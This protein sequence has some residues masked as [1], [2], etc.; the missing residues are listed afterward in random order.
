MSEPALKYKN[1]AIF[2][3]NYTKNCILLLKL[4]ILAVS[5]KGKSRFSRFLPKKFL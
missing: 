1:K 4:P 5:A 2:K 3:Q